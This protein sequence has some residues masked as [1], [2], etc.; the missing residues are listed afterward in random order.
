M[1]A[2]SLITK[3]QLDEIHEQSLHLLE[4]TGV[5]FNHPTALQLLKEHGAKIDGRTARIPETLV[6]RCLDTCPSSFL[7]E[8]RNPEKSVQIGQRDDFVVL[9]NLGP[10]FIQEH[11]GVK[12]RGTMDDF[13]K[14]TKLSNLSAIVDVVGSCPIDACDADVNTKFLHMIKQS[15]RHSDK[16]VMCCTGTPEIN[17]Q[18]LQL[19]EVGFQQP[20]ILEE[21][22]ITGTSLSPLSPL[23]YSDDAS[24]AII[25]FSRAKQMIIIAGAPMSGISAPVSISG[26][27]LMIN[28]EFLA[29][30]V[31]A[32]CAGPGT[33]VI[34]ATTASAG[35]LRNATYVSGIPETSLLNVFAAQMGRYYRVPTRSV[36]TATDAKVLDMQAG[37]EAMQNLQLA[38]LAGIDAIYETLGTLDSLM[39]V[40]Y[41]KF[42][43][44]LELLSRAKIL[45]AGVSESKEQFYREEIENIGIGGNYL[46]TPSTFRACRQRW[47]PSVS[48]WWPF[49]KWADE[50]SLDVHQ[51]A[52]ASF[53]EALESAPE[54]VLDASTDKELSNFI[55]KAGG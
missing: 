8:A 36:G 21:K 28:T 12:R 39:S 53:R 24:H 49:D 43:I 22:V 3:E 7:L 35:N 40:S 46:S 20:G 44:D 2:L 33:P 50:G 30:M 1:L 52:A 23:A 6:T 34:Y 5:S 18:Q 15:F 31:L 32:Q 47:S 38:S 27:S 29:G 11:G 10:V 41:E 48:T 4:N 42:M 54:S 25:A 9:P 45:R 17:D 55:E 51:K 14:I 19:M 13:I 16:P 37:A 26:T